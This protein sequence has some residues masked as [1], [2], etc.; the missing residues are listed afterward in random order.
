VSTPEE[1]GRTLPHDLDAE[2]G[3]LGSMLLSPNAIDEVTAIIKPRD[4]YRPAHQ[5]IHEAILA[6]V[7]EGEPADAITVG[8]LLIERG[9]LGRAGGGGYLHTI[10]ASVPTWAFGASYARI[11]QRLAVR[12]RAI[13]VGTGIVQ[14][15]YE[16]DGDT[17]IAERARTMADAIA[18]ADDAADLLTMDELFAEVIDDLESTAP[19]GVP[20]PWEDVNH[21]IGG[22]MPGQPVI[23]AGRTGS[24][25]SMAALG[26]AAHAAIRERVPT[27]MAT[28]EMT[29]RE[30]MTRLIAAEGRV[31]LHSMVRREV[32]PGDWAHIQAVRERIADAPLAFDDSPVCSVANLRSRLRAMRRK[33]PCGLLVVDYIGLLEG[34]KAES[35]QVEVS[36]M[37]RGLKLLAGEF[38]I[39]VVIVAQLNRNPESRTD[40]RPQASDL[41]DSGSLEQDAS[42]VMLL[43]RPDLN[44]IESPR[45]GE[46]DFV[47]DKNRNGPRCTVTEAFQGHYARIVDMAPVA[48]SPSRHAEPEAA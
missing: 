6:L 36:A 1:F 33:T 8:N 24:A 14:L 40:K 21:V 37:S 15:G 29:R 45:A 18:A 23:I 31:P 41:R 20:T 28:M 7:A 44:E 48:W 9:E 32:E 16:G 4:H 2:R 27:L 19:R 38:A 11:V 46:I 12:R 39:P 35:R 3:A 5:I 25:K 30:V 13:E 34:P 17:D 47:I 22:L 43:H 42:V 26:I 10:L